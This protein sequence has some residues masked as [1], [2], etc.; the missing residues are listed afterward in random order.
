MKYF[1][2]FIITISFIIAGCSKKEEKPLVNKNQY[3]TDTSEIK[4]IPVSNPNEP[5]LLK[6]IYEKGKKY[7]YRISAFSSDIETMKAE[8]TMTQT[9]KQN[10][11]YILELTPLETDQ[12]GTVEISSVISSVKIDALVDGKKITYE[13]GTVKDSSEKIKYAQYEALAK[14]PFSIRVSKTGEILEIMRMDKILNRFFEIN[15]K[16]SSMNSEQKASLRN[17]FIEGLLRPLLN[18][19]FR[20][21]PDHSIARDSSWSIT[22]PPVEAMV[23]KLENKNIYKISSLE[24]LGDDKI[25]IIDG[26]LKTVIT[27]NNKAV[28]RGVSYDFTKPGVTAIGKIYFDITKGIIIK[29]KV[30]TKTNTH[31]TM[32]APSPK[33]TQ[34]GER[35]GTTENTY[36]AELL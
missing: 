22:Q 29:S 4:T 32:K 14:N 24:K 21:I 15:V 28:D 13:S 6:Y 17:N 26:S 33:G 19:I 11:I 25:A 20:P 9:F 8:S 1:F 2:L 12:E 31:F 23:F 36:V 7:N 35:W 34:K 3:A 18:Q 30:N 10:S 27:G 16:A 5:F